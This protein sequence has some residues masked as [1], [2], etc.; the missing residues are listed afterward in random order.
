MTKRKKKIQRR[1]KSTQM[2]GMLKIA[3]TKDQKICVNK[4]YTLFMEQ[5][6]EQEFNG[7]ELW[8]VGVL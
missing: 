8:K 6:S 5:R 4:R 1:V 7:C 2:F 3:S